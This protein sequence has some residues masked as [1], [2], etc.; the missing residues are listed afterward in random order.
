MYSFEGDFRRKPIQALGGVQKKVSAV[1][2]VT[3]SPLESDD[4]VALL[5]S[6][7]LRLGVRLRVR[8]AV[9]LTVASRCDLPPVLSL[10]LVLS[11]KCILQTA[12]IWATYQVAMSHCCI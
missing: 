7:S 9:T 1:S 10:F 2:P 11:Y 4:S 5:E 8:L 3:D 6:V 12:H